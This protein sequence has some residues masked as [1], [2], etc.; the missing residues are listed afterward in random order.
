[1]VQSQF[2]EYIQKYFKGIV[3][4]IVKLL[5]GKEEDAPPSYRFKQMLTPKF[6]VDGKWQSIIG[7]YKNVKADLVAMDSP[8]PVKKRPSLGTASGDIPKSGMKKWL[9]EN[10][11]TNLQ[12]LEALGNVEEVKSELFDDTA[13]CITGLYENNE[14]LFLFGLSSGTALV[15]EEENVGTAARLSYGYLPENK[16]HF[17]LAAEFYCHFTSPIRR[18][19]DLAIHRIIKD[20]LNNGEA[21]FKK[22]RAFAAEAS[23]QSSERERAA[24]KAERDVDDLKKAEYMADKIGNRYAG[25]V[26]GVTEWGI[27][28]ELPNTVEGMVRAENLPGDGYE[29]DRRAVK[30][31]NRIHSYRI[32]DKAEIE[33]AAVNGLKVEFK[34]AESKKPAG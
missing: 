18:Y 7:K 13:A 21:C 34:P 26:S 8:L 24:E 6:S 2:I 17:G 15:T 22:Y 28:V 1:M 33:V 23:K 4:S 11:M 29:Y 5:N 12:T 10:Q 27:F 32:G 14:Y 25:I 3:V 31:S 16:G 19:P 30:L 20:Y 9:N